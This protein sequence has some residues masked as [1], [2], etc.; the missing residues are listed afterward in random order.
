MSSAVT[1]WARGGLALP[2]AP[3]TASPRHPLAGK[4]ERLLG[5]KP[6]P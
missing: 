6:E 2:N 3:T 4:R 1:Q 5:M